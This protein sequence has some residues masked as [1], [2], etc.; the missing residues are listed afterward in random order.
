MNKEIS[1]VLKIS[2]KELYEILGE[3]S[4]SLFGSYGDVYLMEN[5]GRITVYYDNDSLLKEIVIKNYLI[6]TE[7]EI[8]ITIKKE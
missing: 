1:C 5:G 3:P 2:Q 6:N 4:G 7:E 8:K